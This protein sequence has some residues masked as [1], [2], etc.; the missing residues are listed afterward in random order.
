MNCLQEPDRLIVT[1]VSESLI[2]LTADALVVCRVQ[3]FLKVPDRNI[4]KFSPL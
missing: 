4:G 1:L 2:R 3:L